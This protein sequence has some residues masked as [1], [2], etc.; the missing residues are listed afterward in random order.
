MAEIEADLEEVQGRCT[1]QSVQSAEKTAKFHSNPTLT[2]LYTAETVGL[3]R[4][5]NQEDSK[6]EKEKTKKS[7]NLKRKMKRS[8]TLKTTRTLTKRKTKKSKTKFY[9]LFLFLV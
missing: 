3:R 6:E 2:D 5:K 1:L 8:K 7:K 4:E 9:F